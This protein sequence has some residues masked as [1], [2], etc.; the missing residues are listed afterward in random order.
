MPDFAEVRQEN[1]N[2]SKSPTGKAPSIPQPSEGGCRVP[3]TWRLDSISSLMDGKLRT[4]KTLFG[5]SGLKT[6]ISGVPYKAQRSFSFVRLQK[7]HFD[8]RHLHQSRTVPSDPNLTTF[9]TVTLLSV[10]EPLG[11]PA[12]F[13]SKLGQNF[14]SCLTFTNS[15]NTFVEHLTVES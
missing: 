6:G 1:H 11:P 9:H 2:N 4:K 7:R 3:S 12:A 5:V 8:I 13:K 14:S 10:G 15:D